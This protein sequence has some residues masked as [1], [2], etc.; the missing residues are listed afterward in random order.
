[1]TVPATTQ[2]TSLPIPEP[3]MQSTG[4]VELSIVVP[5]YD[6][7]A[8]LPELYRELCETLA[9]LPYRSELIFVDDG[10]TDGSSEV[11]RSLFA[12]DPRVQVIEF[13]RNF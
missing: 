9:G 12:S 6:E 2:V 7:A 3:E 1:M 13:R 11:L 5:V 8:S 10:S 4:G